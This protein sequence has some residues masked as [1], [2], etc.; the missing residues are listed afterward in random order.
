MA[1]RSRRMWC[2]KCFCLVGVVLLP[3]LPALGR[4]RTVDSAAAPHP[5]RKNGFRH[6]RRR[7]RHYGAS[8]AF[9]REG[10]LKNTR[11]IRRA[12]AETMAPALLKAVTLATCVKAFLL[13]GIEGIELM[14]KMCRCPAG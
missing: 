10:G 14:R 4:A 2:D 12:Q 3:A 7:P 8:A 11:D 1:R 6:N 13:P 5:K 9:H